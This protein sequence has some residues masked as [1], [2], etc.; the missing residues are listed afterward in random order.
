MT[1]PIS[2]PAS[3]RARAKVLKVTT[4]VERPPSPGATR[5]PGR[6]SIYAESMR[7]VTIKIPDE[8]MD[9]LGKA[10]AAWSVSMAE[11][12]RTALTEHFK[13]RKIIQ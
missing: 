3:T 13:A 10:S 11:I 4:A 2:V 12:I 9:T 7:T 8:L 5:R 6:P 1:Q